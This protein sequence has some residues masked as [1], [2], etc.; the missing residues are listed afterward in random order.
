MSAI[1]K[2]C[3]GCGKT[4]S[5]QWTTVPAQNNGNSIKLMCADCRAKLSLVKPKGTVEK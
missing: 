1:H 2:P 5:V 3:M 4:T